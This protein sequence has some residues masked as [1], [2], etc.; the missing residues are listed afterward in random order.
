M[1]ILKVAY[2]QG[3]KMKINIDTR[4]FNFIKDNIDRNIFNYLWFYKDCIR[5]SN[6]YSLLIVPCRNEVE[7]IGLAYKTLKDRLATQG[8]FVTLEISDFNIVYDDDDDNYDDYDLVKC[9]FWNN[10]F[11][12]KKMNTK[13]LRLTLQ[14]EGKEFKHKVIVSP[15]IFQNLFYDKAG[16]VINGSKVEAVD[17]DCYEGDTSNL[18]FLTRL[19]KFNGLDK[20]KEFTLYYNELGRERDIYKAVQ[21]DIILYEMGNCV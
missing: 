11:I 2:R 6:S 7:N 20:N 21:G 15:K 3:E 1:K 17:L 12:C 5:I 8:S 19:E 16:L 10:T 14:D 9:S 18:L 13:T 4:V